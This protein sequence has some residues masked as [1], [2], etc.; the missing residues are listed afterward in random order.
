MEESMEVSSS[1]T[2]ASKMNQTEMATVFGEVDHETLKAIRETIRLTK[3]RRVM[4]S[5]KELV[6]RVLKDNIARYLE[7]ARR[8]SPVAST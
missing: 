3:R 4:L 8:Q 7:E 5:Q 1:P 2:G 6:G